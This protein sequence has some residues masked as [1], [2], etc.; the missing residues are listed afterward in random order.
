MFKLQNTPTFSKAIVISLQFD[1]LF[2]KKLQVLTSSEFE[3][4]FYTKLVETPCTNVWILK[5]KTL[6]L[7]GF[8]TLQR[9]ERQRRQRS[10]TNAKENFVVFIV[11]FLLLQQQFGRS[12]FEIELEVWISFTACK[13]VWFIFKRFSPNGLIRMRAV[14][15]T[16]LWL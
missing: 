10:E 16:K 5:A 4:F 11:S 12:Y 3:S 8:E 15:K 14:C 7:R 2:L 9:A 1:E 6:I 13:H